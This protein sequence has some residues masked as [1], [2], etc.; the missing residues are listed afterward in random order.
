M[1]TSPVPIAVKKP[2][3]V[4]EYPSIMF[5]P[6]V[7]PQTNPFGVT[8]TQHAPAK[9]GVEAS[10][11]SWA[12]SLTELE[13]MLGPPTEMSRPLLGAIAKSKM[14]GC[15]ELPPESAVLK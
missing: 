7:E 12:S 6:P 9:M 4:T 1:A 11:V 8:T 5:D 15:M 2:E 14:R 3:A 13:S 10:E